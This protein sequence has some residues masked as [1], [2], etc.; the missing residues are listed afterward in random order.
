MRNILVTFLGNL[1]GCVVSVAIIVVYLA[2]CTFCFMA[3][4]HLFINDA[5]AA[6][7][8]SL[9]AT[10]FITQAGW[11]TYIEIKKDKKP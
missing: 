10:Y 4:F 7:I 11:C 9:T 8:C 5:F 1:I 6:F 2:F 3:L